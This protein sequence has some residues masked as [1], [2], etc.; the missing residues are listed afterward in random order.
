MEDEKFDELTK[1][2]ARPVS[3]RQ[4][5]KVLL[6]TAVGGLVAQSGRGRAFAAGGG[7]SD[8]A[9]FCT[10]LCGC[11]EC[12]CHDICVSNAAHCMNNPG[13]CATSVCN[14][15]GNNGVTPFNICGAAGAIAS[16]CACPTTGGGVCVNSLTD[17]N[18]CGTCGNTCASGKTPACCGGACTDLTSDIN[19]CGTCGTTCTTG[20]TPACCGGT[21]T[22]LAA[23]NN[24]CGACGKVCGTG[25]TCVNGTC[26]SVCTS[27][28]VCGVT[29]P[30]CQTN[31]FCSMFNRPS[32][33]CATPVE[34]GA[35]VCADSCLACGSNTCNTSSDCPSGWHCFATCCGNLCF[36]ACGTLE[37]A[38]ARS[39]TNGPAIDPLGGS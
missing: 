6:A 30:F 9:H 28:F 25:T 5:L 1:Q 18:N 31:V 37:G 38:A 35:T 2:L 3:R 29:T 12:A 19:N 13:A 8:C 27:S 7:N 15:C 22:D 4:I 34:G 39:L 23:D 36:P 14:T 17:V 24:N 11:E 33:I 26:A 21:C 32:C 16:S 20:T 10:A